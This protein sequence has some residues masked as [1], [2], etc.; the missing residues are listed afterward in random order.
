MRLSLPSLSDRALREGKFFCR[1]VMTHQIRSSDGIQSIAERK[2]LLKHTTT[3][4][5]LL[6]KNSSEFGWDTDL[7]D[8][9]IKCICNTYDASYGVRTNASGPHFHNSSVRF[10]ALG[11]S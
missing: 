4:M 9:Q 3:W 10:A 11:S 6:H 7:S 5:T 2:T 1:D 8:F